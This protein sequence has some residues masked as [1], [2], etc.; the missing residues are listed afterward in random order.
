[1]I[2]RIFAQVGD[3]TLTAF[4]ALIFG[5][6]RVFMNKEEMSFRGHVLTILTC[7]AVGTL[8]GQTALE[9]GLPDFVSL[10][11][12]SVFSLVSRDVVVG[13]MNKKFLADLAARASENLVDK[14]T[15]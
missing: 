1:M 5:M 2:E 10:S 6:I 13:L 3:I 12:T 8:A 15:K 7:V 14:V 9:M 4:V 11:I